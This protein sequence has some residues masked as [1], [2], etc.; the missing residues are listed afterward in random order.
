MRS[1]LEGVVSTIPLPEGEPGVTGRSIDP[2]GRV[3]H[4]RFHAS[5]PV[6][7]VQGAWMKETPDEVLGAHGMW[8]NAPTLTWWDDATTS[9]VLERTLSTSD[10]FE[11]MQGSLQGLRFEKRPIRMA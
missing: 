4:W 5:K 10:R 7:R 11:E 6:H 9:Q 1:G 8:L 2:R 3:W